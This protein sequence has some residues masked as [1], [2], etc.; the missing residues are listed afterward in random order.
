MHLP[1]H[2]NT[3]ATSH[4]RTPRLLALIQIPLVLLLPQRH[5]LPALHALDRDLLL[6]HPMPP[7]EP[8]YQSS[9][10]IIRFQRPLPTTNF[11]NTTLARKVKLR[12]EDLRR[13]R[14]SRRLLAL[15]CHGER[16]VAEVEAIGDNPADRGDGA[17]AHVRFRGTEARVGAKVGGR[18]GAGRGDGWVGECSSQ[19]RLCDADL[20]FGGAGLGVGG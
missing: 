14:L 4:D 20:A 8:L 1:L 12:Q 10:L 5:T 18:A 7:P 3:R 2:R 15:Q 11:H 16:R 6:P 9:I 19:V 13:R 17:G